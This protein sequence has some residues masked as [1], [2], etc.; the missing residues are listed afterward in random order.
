MST[1]MGRDSISLVFHHF[2]RIE[3]LKKKSEA[4]QL[5]ILEE[6]RERDNLEKDMESL[7]A[8]LAQV[9]E[10]LSRNIATKRDYDRTISESEAAYEKILESSQVLLNM[11][12]RE[13][14]CLEKGSTT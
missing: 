1:I 6:E 13:A 9:N 8:R 14:Q 12:R 2:R 4:L 3:N 11:L 5:L 7:T 10:N